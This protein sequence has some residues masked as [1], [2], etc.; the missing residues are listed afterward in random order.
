MPPQ[1]GLGIIAID[2]AKKV[3]FIHLQVIPPARC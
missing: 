2:E 3:T 1:S